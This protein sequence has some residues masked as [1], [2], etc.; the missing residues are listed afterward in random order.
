MSD[1][2]NPTPRPCASESE[3]GRYL[4]LKELVIEPFFSFISNFELDL[5]MDNLDLIL[6]NWI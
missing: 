4:D 6:N 1:V 5:F 3:T 2:V